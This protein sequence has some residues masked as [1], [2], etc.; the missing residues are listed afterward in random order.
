MKLLRPLLIASFLI[1]AT[2]ACNR[3]DHTDHDGHLAKV[4]QDGDK[5]MGFSHEKTTHRFR[6]FEN[7]GA[8]EVTAKDVADAASRDQIRQHL[9]HIREMFAAGNFEAPM[10]VHSKVPP[11]VEVLKERK[12]EVSYEFEELEN[13]ARVRIKTSDQTA[14]AAVHE[15]L[16]FQIIDHKTGDT[17]EITKE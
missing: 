4:N 13:G 16:K 12:A 10:L 6:L 8:I 9:K 15:F 2:I 5:V 17:T 7:G 11:G 14:L 1:F 3:S